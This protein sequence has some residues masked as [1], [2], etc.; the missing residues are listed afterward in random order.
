MWILC[1]FPGCGVYTRIPRIGPRVPR[2][3]QYPQDQTLSLSLMMT[4]V[5]GPRHPG[6]S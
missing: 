2:I 6:P 4:K 1:T 5:S 3:L